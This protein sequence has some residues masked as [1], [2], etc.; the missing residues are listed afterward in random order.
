MNESV[1]NM[2]AGSFVVYMK[3]KKFMQMSS[4]NYNFYCTYLST[5]YC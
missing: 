4:K 3:L 1:H 2:C 5:I